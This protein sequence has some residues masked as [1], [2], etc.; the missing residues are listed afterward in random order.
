MRHSPNRLKSLILTTIFLAHELS[1]S[2]LS[3]VVFLSFNLT[4]GFAAT[5]MYKI[6]TP[7]GGIEGNENE[8]GFGQLVPLLLLLLPAL[9]MVEIYF[10]RGYPQEPCMIPLT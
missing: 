1:F 8:M 4:Y 6:D 3:Q 2:F 7:F 5:I 9:A 10:G